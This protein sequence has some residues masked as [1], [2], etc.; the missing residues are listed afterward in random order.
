MNDYA[1]RRC[2]SPNVRVDQ[3]DDPDK[4][5]GLKCFDCG[6]YTWPPKPGNEERRRDH[7]SRWRKDWRAQ[8]G[9]EL[10]C[11]WCRVRESQT[12]TG[13]DIDHLT[14]FEA[15]GTDEFANTMPLCRNCHTK[16]H[17]EQCV[18]QHLQGR[19]ARDHPEAA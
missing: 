10:I 1:C 3:R 18:I 6:H 4:P 5:I 8:L 2:G 7:N 12:R 15:G 9:G 17:A 19:S 11:M 14:P 13:F 16:R